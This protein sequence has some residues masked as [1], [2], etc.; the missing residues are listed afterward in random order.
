M[1]NL[2]LVSLFSAIALSSLAQDSLSNKTLT[3]A[4]YFNK[5]KRQK[6]GAWVLTAAGTVGLLGTLMAD[7]SQTVGGSMLYL[8]SAGSYHQEYKSYTGAYLLSGSCVVG[9]ILLFNAAAKNNKKAKA[10]TITMQM[11]KT[12]QLKGNVVYKHSFP[13]ACVKVRL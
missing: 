5:N 3:Q 11:E 10:M 8:L 1:R 7:A 13:S 4:D 6:T 12:D 2:M 9:G